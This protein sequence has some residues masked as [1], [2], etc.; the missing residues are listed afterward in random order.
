VVLLESGCS[1]HM[2]WDKVLF[3]KFKSLT[4]ELVTFGGG[5]TSIIE[6]KRSINILGL[7]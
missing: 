1:G 5:N 6:G 3:K 4:R 7:P 2:S